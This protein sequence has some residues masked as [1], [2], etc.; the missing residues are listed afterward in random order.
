MRI[1]GA[2]QVLVNAVFVTTTRETALG[3]RDIP[4][5]AHVAR[6]RS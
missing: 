6:C 5:V 3:L 1:A 4:G 2:D